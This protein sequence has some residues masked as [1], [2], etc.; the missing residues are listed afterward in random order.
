MLQHDFPSLT[1]LWPIVATLPYCSYT[2]L[3]SVGFLGAFGAETLAWPSTMTRSYL[4]GLLWRLR[5]DRVG[6]LL[7]SFM[8][9]R[10]RWGA[11]GALY[12]KPAIAG[13]NSCLRFL[14]VI[15]LLLSGVDGW[16]LRSR[17]L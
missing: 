12:P 8:L 15:L 13:P 9:G 17:G 14:L 16:V 11:S 7:L 1:L 6:F 3:V 4:D 2:S 10:A 5:L